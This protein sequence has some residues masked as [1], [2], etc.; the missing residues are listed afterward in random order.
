MKFYPMPMHLHAAHEPTA[1]IG[2]HMS[3]ARRLG[4]RHLWLTEHDS[5]MGTKRRP[6]PVFRFPKKKLFCDLPGGVRAGLRP[7]EGNSG[8]HTFREEEDGIAAILTARAGERESMHFYSMG[9]NHSD[10]LFSVVTVRLDGE[11]TA[12]G[13]ATLTVE[14]ILSAQPPSGE[15]AR[16][17]YYLG[18]AP[19]REPLCLYYPFPARGEDGLYRFPLTEDTREEIGGLDNALAKVRFR[20]IGGEGEA[21]LTLRALYFDRLLNYEAVRQEQIRLASALGRAYAVTPVV[22]FEISEAGHHKNCY[23]THVPVIDYASR[24]YAVTQEEAIAHVRAYGG[25]FCYNH[26]FTEWKNAELTEEERLALVD[27]LTEELAAS[28]VWGASLMEVGFPYRKEG[29]YDRHYLRLWDGL[30]RHGVF[31][32]GDGDSDNHM[33]TAEGWLYG[34]NFVT[35]VGLSDGEE[36]TEEA[37]VGALVRGACFGADPTAVR[38]LTLTTEDGRPMGS[39][40]VGDEVTVTLAAARIAT[41]GYA[42]R[43]VNGAEDGRLPIVNGAIRDRYTLVSDGL[44]SFVRYEIRRPSGI[45]AAF[46]NP[47]YLVKDRALVPKAAEGRL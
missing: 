47:I 30:S 20:L 6:L 25:I 7:E 31:I 24:G 19:V 3:W 37:I 26:P 13:G 29:F 34:N 40:A 16:L 36:P 32:T 22:S 4:L 2:M 11:V 17:V 12:C 1:S 27:D 46:T 8:S 35:F 39:I 10:P 43:I 44:Y 28:H 38:H 18:K 41:G 9:K 15:Q 45:L 42:V 5:R 33:A 23:S 14:F 21:S